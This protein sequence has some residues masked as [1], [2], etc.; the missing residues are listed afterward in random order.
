MSNSNEDNDESV[1]VSISDA[2]DGGNGKLMKVENNHETTVYVNHIK[3][4]PFTQLEHCHHFQYFSFHS[5]V[6]VSTTS[7]P[8][9]V[10]YVLANAGKASYSKAWNDSTAFVSTTPSDPFSWKRKLD[11]AYDESV[12]ELSWTHEHTTDSPSAYFA[13]FP[14]YCYERH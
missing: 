4:D 7:S 11:T 3:K 12:G 10:K 6:S 8:I 14:P 2:F 9:K 13:Y 1:K 5:S